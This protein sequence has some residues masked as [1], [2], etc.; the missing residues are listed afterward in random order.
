MRLCKAFMWGFWS[1]AFI[2]GAKSFN[3]DLLHPVVYQTK[4]PSDYF[5]FSLGLHSGNENDPADLPW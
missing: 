2:S 1:L 5:G 4:F 3:L